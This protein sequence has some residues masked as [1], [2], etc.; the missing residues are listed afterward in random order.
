MSLIEELKRRNVFRVGLA[1]VLV[2]WVTLQGADF[3]LDL[4]GAPDWVIRA[5][6]VSVAIGL[7]VAL[8]FAWAFELTPEGIKREHEVDRTTSITP[9]TGR[10]LDRLIIV[11][12]GVL[13]AWLLF[14]EFYL[15]PREAAGPKT[16]MQAEVGDDRG[17][18]GSPDFAPKSIAV[19]PFA[20]LSQ[21]QD[22][23]WFADGLAEEIL[24][25]LARAPDLLVASRTASF[26]YRDTEQ[27]LPEVARELGVDHILE[28]S[29]R[30]AG[31]RIRVT[32]QLIRAGDGF[33]VWSQNYDRDAD[34][35]IAIQ[36][37]LAVAIAA[38]L[39]STMDPET[40]QNML[41]AGTRNVEAYELY[42]EGLA[43]RAEAS[44]EADFS[45]IETSYESF[46]KARALDPGFS[47]AHAA[48][49]LY[50]RWNLA[51]ARRGLSESNRSLDE[52]MDRF[53]ERIEAAI[54]TA[55]NAVERQ[56]NELLLAMAQMR[57][58]DA[59]RLGR[60]VLQERPFDIET[61]DDFTDAAVYAA[62]REALAEGTDRALAMAERGMIDAAEIYIFNEWQ[63]G[64][65]LR[66]RDAFVANTMRFMQR[67]PRPGLAYQAHR[68]LL[69]IDEVEKARSLLPLLES[70]DEGRDIV[71]ARQ[72]CAEGR[73]GDAE[74]I[75]AALPERWETERE[76]LDTRLW[77]LYEMLGMDDEAA[78][79]LK[80]YESLAAPL[81]V[82]NYLTYPQFDPEPFPVVMSILEREGVVRPPPVQPGFQCPP[83]GA[84]RASV[85]VLPFRAMSSGE[86]DE[87]FADG[88][89]EEI[90][91]ALAQLPE[92]LVTAR[93]SSF[94]FKDQDLPVPE[95]AERLGVAHVVEGS[96]RRAG[97]RVRI[98]A[99]LIRAADGFHLWSNTYDRTLEDVFA[100]QEDIAANIAETLDV[101]LDEDKLG[102]MRRSGIGDI[103]AFIAFQKGRELFVESHDDIA[104]IEQTLPTMVPYFEEALA[105][106]PGL[107]A[108]WIYKADALAHTAFDIAAGVREERFAGEAE[109]AQRTIS[110]ELDQAWEVARPGN[111]RDILDVERTIF[112]DDWS[113]LGQK[114]ERALAPGDCPR[115]NW[116]TEIATM[117]GSPERV[118]LKIE[119]QVRCDPLNALVNFHHAYNALWIGNPGEALRLARQASSRG[120]DFSWLEG[121]EF[122]ALLALGEFDHPALRT[123]GKVGWMPYDTEMVTAA[124][125]GDLETARQLAEE[126]WSSEEADDQSSLIAAAMVGDLERANGFAARIDARP[127]GQLVLNNA[128]FA[129]KC[130]S[131]FTLDATPNFA[132]RLAEAGIV[133]SPGT[134]VRYPAKDW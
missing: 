104:R 134:V 83:P 115:V 58:R 2:A 3:V 30:R 13:V 51:I 17:A 21:G 102:L 110:D 125:R 103:E 44:I 40:L 114:I 32:A 124:A 4:I 130:G 33:H 48:A 71:Q 131:P 94:F 122:M 26:A 1:Y 60:A 34:D 25:A 64:A 121:V 91:N 43:Q 98:T 133:W 108:A 101:V 84:D 6:A 9:T 27:P 66:D 70:D 76:E 41:S 113:G 117:L 132:R 38:A 106:S 80:P 28:G 47:S 72:A 87:Y 81:A 29:V 20:D 93:T 23:A 120:I 75:L 31:D 36:E 111:Q 92:L 116:T 19:L 127:G 49:A 55:P 10:R 46:E 74:A 45:L 50:W 126:Y 88:L 105:A 35:I 56:R 79:V 90:L 52:K 73:R 22:Q 119:E 39:Q 12:L 24:N 18:P 37:D 89:T 82:G 63:I 16:A 14:D 107:L 53:R 78:Q 62:D 7:P 59:I 54:E 69:W 61:L 15:E 67:F 96:V 129:C 68:A 99:Q 85:A 11:F 8:V 95:I 100:V 65:E 123:G 57:L 97:E 112:S 109:Q 5:L 128:A 42:L 77:H 86:D 118:R